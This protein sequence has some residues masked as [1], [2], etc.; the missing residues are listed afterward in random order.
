MIWHNDKTGQATLRSLVAYDHSSLGVIHLE[1]AVES[2]GSARGPSSSGSG[3]SADLGAAGGREGWGIR[4]A[5]TRPG[6]SGENGPP[7]SPGPPGNP[8]PPCPCPTPTAASGARPSNA[9]PSAA[10]SHA[11]TPS[12]STSWTLAVPQPTPLSAGSQFRSPPTSA[13]RPSRTCAPATSAACVSDPA[14]TGTTRS[15]GSPPPWSAATSPSKSGWSSAAS[16]HP[17]PGIHRG[18]SPTSRESTT[19]YPVGPI[20]PLPACPAPMTHTPSKSRKDR[21]PNASH[22]E[23]AR[24]QATADRGATG[25]GASAHV[26]RPGSLTTRNPRALE[27]SFR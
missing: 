23:G 18:A 1:R 14:T 3:G 22:R 21:V 11:A 13:S 10:V 5:D 25:A 17:Q 20:H 12:A 26:R 16:P 27:V 7:P 9:A 6:Q 24:L 15:A 4:V 2:A 8:P 19:D